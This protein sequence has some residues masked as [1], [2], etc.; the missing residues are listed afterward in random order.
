MALQ[1]RSRERAPYPPVDYQAGELVN[2]VHALRLIVECLLCGESCEF[3]KR[4]SV[5]WYK[6]RHECLFKNPEFKVER[7]FEEVTI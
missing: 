6:T 7:K 4:G 3:T 2:T 1:T 5:E